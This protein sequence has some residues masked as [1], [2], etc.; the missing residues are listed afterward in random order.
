M[1]DFYSR[2]ASASLKK[3]STADTP[4]TP[5][6]FFDFLSEDIA[7]EY[8]YTP[9]M[10]IENNRTKNIRPVD[11]KITA[12]TGS[13]TLNV[14]PKK[15]GHFVNGVFGG[16]TTGR[17]L[18]IG[19]A[20]GTFV[21]AETVTGGTSSATGVV[22]AV[23]EDYLLITGGSGTFTAAETITGGTSSAT[24][25]VTSYVA[26]IYGHEGKLPDSSIPTYSLQLN[27]DQIAIRYFGLRFTGFDTINQADN[28]ITAQVQVKAKGQ[29]RH[30]YVTAI[31]T[32][33]S[34]TKTL[35]V[36]Q[37]LGLVASDTIKVFR[38]ST[39]LFLDFST[40][41]VKT[42]TVA[43]VASATTITV[44]NLETA[45]AVG[46]LIVLAPQTATYT[47]GSEFSWF[48]GTVFKYGDTVATLATDC[49][50]DFEFT[51][52]N[53][54][55]ERYG[56]CGA[57]FE[58]RFP[59][60]LVQ[61]GLEAS[62]SFTKYYDTEKKFMKLRRNTQQAI[63][64]DTYGAVISGTTRNQL[65]IQFPG[66]NFDT[67]ETNITEDDIVN[68]EVPFTGFYNATKAY[69]VKVVLVNDVSSY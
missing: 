18:P 48:G 56:A 7:T 43:S 51:I 26:T 69:T 40:T 17:W 55:E 54:F 21:V 65:R 61:K 10:P 41:G 2:V 47:I 28:V 42:H 64:F 30:A 35:T 24:A 13:I 25:S 8:A 50:E 49:A 27:Y 34:G 39:G 11:N 14:E 68:E 33:G 63:Q 23:G 1:A 3:E 15:F 52:V 46:D 20:T 62:G 37:T 32:A 31:T 4:V 59:S 67:Y 12:P 44:T 29:F 22:A 53:E 9:S 57:D 38:P 58:H 60:V 19:T 36:D 45:L 66:V 5:D 6:T 16:V